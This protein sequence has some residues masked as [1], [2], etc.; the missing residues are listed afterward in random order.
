MDIGTQP[1][2]SFIPKA[3]LASATP[4]GYRRATVGIMTLVAAIL[5]ITSVALAAGAFV[6]EKYLK[7]SL[8]QKQADLEKAR[9][10]F[11]PA[12]I[13]EIRRLDTRIEH[14]KEILSRH[15]AFSSL[16]DILS[17]STLQNIQF[18]S[19]SLITDPNGSN[20]QISLKGFG[21]SY[22]SVALQADAFNK[23]PGFKDPIFSE[24]NLDQSGKVSF[25]FKA[26][27]DSKNFK[28]ESSIYDSETSRIEE[29]ILLDKLPEQSF[30]SE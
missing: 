8:V 19:F 18:K 16:F 14:S 7:S 4:S 13:E 9:G 28:Y 15:V 24:L 20:S 30:E 27:I 25:S 21:R 10:A 11:D 17:R 29:K 5:F 6:Y 23:V 22:A 26:S 3:P 2:V 1:S 12:L